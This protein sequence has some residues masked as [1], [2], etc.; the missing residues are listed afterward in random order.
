M[1]TT[2]SKS[3]A[4]GVRR[5]SRWM[6][7]K[8][9]KP[10]PFQRAVWKSIVA[11]DNGI[12][13]SPTGTGKTLAIWLGAI[14]AWYEQQSAGELQSK[15]EKAQRKT[16][17]V[18]RNNFESIQVIWLTPLRAL[19]ADTLLALQEP[20]TDLGLPWLVERRTSDTSSSVKTKQ[21]N[22]LPSCLITTPE[23]LSILLSYPKTQSQFSSLKLIVLDEWHELMGTKRGV[24]AE[25]GL[26][27]L[28]SLSPNVRTWAVSATIGNVEQAMQ[29]AIGCAVEQGSVG[30]TVV[31]APA[32]RK[33]SMKSLIPET[34]ERF[35]WAGH[36]GLKSLPAV[37][38]AIESVRSSLIFT[39]TRSQSEKWYS[40]I[41][42][43]KP[44]WAGKIGLHHGS[45]DRGKR[46]WVERELDAGNL[47][48]VVCTSSLDLGVDFFPVEQVM[49]VGSPKGIA[50]LMQ[51]A[52]RSGHYP[53]G[54]SQLVFVPTHAL[55]LIELAAAKDALKQNRIESRIPLTGSLD[56]LTQ[57]VV[58]LAAGTPIDADALFHEVRR[59]NAF[60][61]LTEVEW[62]WVLDFVQRGGESLRA[63]PD[64]RRVVD[65]EEGLAVTDDKIAKRHRMSIGTISSDREVLVKFLKGG[66]L[67]TIEERF[68]SKLKPGDN[69]LFAGRTLKLVMIRDMTAWV[70][71]AKGKVAALPRWAG[72]RLPLS[73]EL[74]EAVRDKL[75][76]AK[77]GKFNGP[78]M[79]AVKPLLELQSQW[80]EI[81]DES[82]LLIEQVKTRDG[83]HLF[84]Y[85]FEGRLVHEGLAAI[86]AW[87]MSRLQPITFA[88][89]INDYGIELLSPTEP[90]L[91]KA[92]ESGLFQTN[93][94]L[95]QIDKSMNAGELDRRQFRDIARIAGLVFG[96]LPGQGKS[97]RQLQ[98]S[99]DMFF[100]V[101]RE[102]DS[103]NL[104]LKQAR[105]EVLDL[106]LEHQRLSEAMWRLSKAR[107]VVKQ[108]PKPT[109]LAFPI[110]VDRLRMKLSSEKLADRIARLTQQF[111]KAT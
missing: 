99:S 30:A 45:L 6:N 94:L 80:S 100:D 23:S 104:L 63:Y 43:A 74:S 84:V 7:S 108:P 39:N 71:R 19:A 8:E 91:E 29:T 72:G 55:E 22:R 70:K 3:K 2:I 102:Y 25:L 5:V 20:V 40:A 76:D 90:P 89:T 96:G 51:R 21:K 31:K 46:A 97:S 75:G 50:R 79:K 49:Q 73:S 42:H 68:V 24:Q 69:F 105:R 56:V 110:L 98:A 38:E 111:E 28:R 66:R 77:R 12:L 16:K 1:N 44:E 64:F 34:I 67:G 83:Y 41:L 78:E 93:N 26:S 4:S 33:L 37:I 52:G 13:H 87:R 101:F 82:S 27:R 92:I 107:L 106:Q 81:P 95:D 53:G 47:H 14:A 88:T 57:H 60:Q 65:S 11:G 62:Q 10:F 58:T 32:R 109:P 59:T 17:R 9:R 54:K 103:E 85:P 15:T 18:N 35:P 48:C 86:L 36:M 61:D